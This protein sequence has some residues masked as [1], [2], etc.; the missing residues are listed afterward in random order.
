MKVGNKRLTV[1][2][3]RYLHIIYVMFIVLDYYSKL[4]QILPKNPLS[5][6]GGMNVRRKISEDDGI[7]KVHFHVKKVENSDRNGYTVFH[8]KEI[9]ND[10]LR[11]YLSYQD[12]V[13]P[14]ASSARGDDF[15]ESL[16]VSDV[17][18]NESTMYFEVVYVDNRL[19]YEFVRDDERVRF[20]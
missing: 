3:L 11:C 12:L 6:I 15:M 5:I 4:F 10:Y 14:Y 2:D 17:Y 13:R 20:I 1:K 16:Y 7:T 18:E 8:I 19:A 9:L